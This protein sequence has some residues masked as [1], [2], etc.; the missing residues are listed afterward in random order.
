MDVCNAEHAEHFFPRTNWEI[1]EKALALAQFE[2]DKETRE[3][4]FGGWDIPFGV[5]A[6]KPEILT[7]DPTR[8]YSIEELSYILGQ[9]KMKILSTFSE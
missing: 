4:L 5:P 3:M 9:R 6:Q 2:W 1:G 7:G 8:L